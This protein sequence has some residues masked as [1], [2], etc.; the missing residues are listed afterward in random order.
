MIFNENDLRDARADYAGQTIS[1]RLGCYDVLHYGHQK[2]LDFAAAQADLLAVGVMADEYIE[3][4][5]GRTPINP[6]QHRVEAID[7]AHN[8]DISFVISSFSARAI[9]RTLFRLRPD[10]YVEDEEHE[11][12]ISKPILL[13]LM[14]TEYVIDRVSRVASSTAIIARLGIAGAAQVSSLEFRPDSLSEVDSPVEVVDAA[15]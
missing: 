8:V 4:R 10:V 13:S 5:K 1:L 9:A 12:K 2:G 15:A 3:Q 14:G 11:K 6:E 7:A